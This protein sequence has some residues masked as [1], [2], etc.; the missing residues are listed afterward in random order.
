MKRLNLF[1]DCPTDERAAPSPPAR[2][3]AAAWSVLSLKF[4]GGIEIG[5]ET[6]GGAPRC[7]QYIRVGW[8]N[9]PRVPRWWFFERSLTWT[10]KHRDEGHWRVTDRMSVTIP[11]LILA[12]SLNHGPN[13]VYAQIPDTSGRF[14]PNTLGASAPPQQNIK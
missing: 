10:C 4:T 5:N 12:S 14:L 2:T 8:G 7:C 13:I 9:H 11:L 1:A 6:L 3:H